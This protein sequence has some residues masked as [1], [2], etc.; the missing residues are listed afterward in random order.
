MA[1]ARARVVAKVVLA[2][3]GAWLLL[4]TLGYLYEAKQA[5]DDD[6]ISQKAGWGWRFKRGHQGVK[7]MARRLTRRAPKATP[8]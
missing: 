8:K 4:L 3:L 7:S 5:T 6:L 1:E 2:G